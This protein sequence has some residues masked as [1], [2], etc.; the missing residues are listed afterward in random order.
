M[1]AGLTGIEPISLRSKRSI[2]SI[3]RKTDY[4]AGPQGFEPWLTESKSVVLPLHY[5]PA[6]LAA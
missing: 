4:R 2:L 5:G 1:L 6:K 3:E